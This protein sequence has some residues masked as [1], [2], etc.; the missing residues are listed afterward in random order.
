MP[1]RRLEPALEATDQA[2]QIRALGAV[3][4]MQL[5]D[6]QIAQRIRLLPRPQRRIGSADQQEIQHLVVGQQDVRRVLAQGMA[7]RDDREAAIGHLLHAAGFLSRGL[8]HVQAG[9]DTGQS[10]CVHNLLG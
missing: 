9:A 10:R 1:R 6:H 2:C 4:S 5:I 8:A 3:E 7:V